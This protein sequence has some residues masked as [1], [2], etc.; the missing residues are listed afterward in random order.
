VYFRGV[1][2]ATYPLLPKIARP[3][4]NKGLKSEGNIFHKFFT[5]G[6]K[7]IKNLNSWEILFL[8]RHHG[9]P[10]RLLDWTESFIIALYFALRK[11]QTDAD[12]AIW[13]LNS[14]NLCIQ[15]GLSDKNLFNSTT[16]GFK[17]DDF[18]TNDQITLLK[19]VPIQPTYYHERFIAQSSI[20]TMHFVLT[21]LDELYKENNVLLKLSL[22]NKLI[23][24]AEYFLYLNDINEHKLFPDLDGLGSVL[25][26]EYF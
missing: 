14:D 9:V 26:N 5:E 6:A 19:V 11:R 10:T 17:Y 23:P 1:N 16:V 20:F 15:N 22:P 12:V 21:P 4:Y 2:N 13:V 18:I 3:E 7:D 24:A 25:E 8:M